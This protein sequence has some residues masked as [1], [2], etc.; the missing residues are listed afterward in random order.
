MWHNLKDPIDVIPIPVGVP[1]KFVAS[2]RSTQG[3][4]I[5]LGSKDGLTTF[6][7]VDE[8]EV[9][10]DDAS[11]FRDIT[12]SEEIQDGQDVAV[13][14]SVR[15][16]WMSQN[17]SWKTVVLDEYETGSV[18]RL[19]YHPYLTLGFSEGDMIVG[20]GNARVRPR[21]DRETGEE[22]DEL[23]TVVFATGYFALTSSFPEDIEDVNESDIGFGSGG[24][25]W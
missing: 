4:T 23:E 15:N 3:D 7:K 24:E 6:A 1:V 5:T 16:I 20:L 9:S 8:G 18:I 12:L 22:L 19:L 17:S 2:V 13:M 25:D 21:I 14:G 10:L 11:T